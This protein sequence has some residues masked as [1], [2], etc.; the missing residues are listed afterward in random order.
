MGLAVGISMVLD[1]LADP[2]FGAWSDRVRSRLGRRLPLMLIAAPL[3]LLTMG[4]LFSPPAGL[5]PY[6]LFF[7]LM[8]NKM[9]VRAFASMFFV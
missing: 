6:L 5:A 4:L 1:A 2:L 9:G 8:L 3:T 7:W